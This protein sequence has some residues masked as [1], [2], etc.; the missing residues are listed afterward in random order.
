[1]TLYIREVTIVDEYD[2]VLLKLK[3]CPAD[4][5]LK[6]CLRIMEQKDGAKQVKGVIKSYLWKLDKEMADYFKL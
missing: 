5:G 2:N 4:T 3:N 6:K 1:M